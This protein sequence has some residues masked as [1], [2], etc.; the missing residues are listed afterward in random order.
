MRHF[1]QMLRQSLSRGFDELALMQG[2]TVWRA[3]LKAKEPCNETHLLSGG[4]LL[5]MYYAIGK[6]GQLVWS[7]YASQAHLE[8]AGL[9]ARHGPN[10][11]GFFFFMHISMS[12]VQWRPI[13]C[14]HGCSTATNILAVGQLPSCGLELQWGISIGSMLSGVHDT[15]LPFASLDVPSQD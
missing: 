7:M 15:D 8:E 4:K 1:G 6:H 5:A 9:S 11:L 14:G 10:Y 12:N 2:T 3:R 13:L